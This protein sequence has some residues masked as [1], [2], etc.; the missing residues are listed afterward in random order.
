MHTRISLG[1][2]VWMKPVDADSPAPTGPAALTLLTMTT[3]PS[4]GVLR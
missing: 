4:L 2:E 3:E 1:A